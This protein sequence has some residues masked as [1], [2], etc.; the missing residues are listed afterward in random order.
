MEDKI[1]FGLAA[2]KYLGVGVIESI[3][4]ARDKGDAF[5]SLIDY[6]KQKDLGKRK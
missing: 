3:L 2:V 5:K 1:R 6:C 4:E